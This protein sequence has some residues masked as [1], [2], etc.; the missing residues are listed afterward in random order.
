M[1]PLV[2][3]TLFDSIWMITAQ[4]SDMSQSEMCKHRERFLIFRT[5]YVCSK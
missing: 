5:V 1:R 2:V 4:I 3:D